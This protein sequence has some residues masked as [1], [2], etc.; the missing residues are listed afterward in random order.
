MIQADER[1]DFPFRIDRLMCLQM[2]EYAPSTPNEPLIE[3]TIGQ[4]S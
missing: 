2:S 3:L 4:R 1:A